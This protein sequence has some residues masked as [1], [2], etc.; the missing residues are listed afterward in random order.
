[1]PEAVKVAF[2]AVLGPGTR[3]RLAREIGVSPEAVKRWFSGRWPAA[4][5]Q[6]FA[7][8]LIRHADAQQQK[9]DEIK[10]LAQ[11]LLT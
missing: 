6:Q 4:R 5:K 3:K 9:L 11:S 2:V 7:F 8:L 1:M 10:R